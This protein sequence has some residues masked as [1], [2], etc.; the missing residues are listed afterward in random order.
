MSPD[1]LAAVAARD[2]RHSR[3]QQGL[4]VVASDP[5]VVRLTATLL[6]S[7][8]RSEDSAEEVRLVG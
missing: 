3:R 7:A 8:M 6:A 2:A 4:G 1:N 5:A